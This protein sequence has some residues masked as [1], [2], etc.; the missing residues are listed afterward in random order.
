MRRL[1][2]ATVE[3]INGVPGVGLTIAEAV[4]SFFQNNGKLVEEL[5]T[6]GLNLAEPRITVSEGPLVGKTYVITGTLPSLSR[7]EATRLIEQAG[8]R[9][10][11]SVSKKTDAVV[12]GGEAGGKLEKAQQL[13]VAIIDEAELLRRVES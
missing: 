5:E 4:V 1:A 2:G 3:E 9:V 8:G 13:G 6:L 10:S 7:A 11:G 12:A